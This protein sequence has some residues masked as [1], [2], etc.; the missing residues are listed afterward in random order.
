MF[1]ELRYIYYPDTRRQPCLSELYL[2]LTR[3][4]STLSTYYPPGG[5]GVGAGNQKAEECLNWQINERSEGR[6][7]IPIQVVG[8]CLSVVWW[9]DLDL[10]P[11]GESGSTCPLPPAAGGLENNGAL[12]RQWHVGGS[13]LQLI[14]NGPF[15]LFSVNVYRS[16]HS[17][18][19]KVGQG[20]HCIYLCMCVCEMKPCFFAFQSALAIQ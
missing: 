4:G 8:K 16:L 2:L 11:E 19:C 5:W 17:W 18:G 13:W 9:K 12:A 14:E 3:S 20:G 6:L 7:W 10:G 15:V 1:R